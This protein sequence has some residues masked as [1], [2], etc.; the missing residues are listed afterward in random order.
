METYCVSCNK[1]IANK[2]SRVRR[3]K[4]NRLML[5]SNRVACDKKKLSFMKNQEASRLS[6]KL[7]I[8]TSL[9]HIPLIR[10]ISF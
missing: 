1:N 4:K 10:N 2:N 3:T 9:S 7:A 6:S 5:I 8:K